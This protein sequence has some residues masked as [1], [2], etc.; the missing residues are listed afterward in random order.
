MNVLSRGLHT[1]T[2]YYSHRGLA[3]PRLPSEPAAFLIHY[4]DLSNDL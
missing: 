1:L 3:K 2:G 4:T